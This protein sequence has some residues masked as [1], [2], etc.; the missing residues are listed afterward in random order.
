MSRRLSLAMP[1]LILALSIG[2]AAKA[3]PLSAMLALATL[4]LV[5]LGPRLELDKGRQ[6]LTSAIGGATGY[7]SATLLHEHVR[8]ALSEGWTRFASA[9]LLAAAVRFLIIAVRGGELPELALV[10]VGLLATGKTRDPAYIG[11]V[12][13]F[14]LSTLYNVSSRSQQPPARKR[15]LLG[16]ALLLI[17]AGLGTGTTLGVR[18]LHALASGRARYT[19][20]TW[21]PQIGFSDNMDLGALQGLLDSDE[22]V[23]RVRGARVDYLRGVSLD[24]YEAG[25]WRKSEAAEQSEDAQYLGYPEAPGRVTIT[26]LAEG[27]RFFLPLERRALTTSPAN[28]RVDGMTA[29]E[30]LSKKSLLTASFLPVAASD[31]LA[32][33]RKF[34]RMVPRRMRAKLEALAKEWT[35]GSLTASEELDALERHLRTEFVYS[36]KFERHKRRDPLVDFLFHRRKGHCEY[37]ASALALLARV[38]GIPTRV[39]MG[40]RVAERSPF[41]YYMVRQRNAHAWVEAWLPEQG[42]LTRD[43]T[44]GEHLPQN[45]DHQAGLLES[46]VDA[47]GVAYDDVTAWLGRLT[48]LQTSVA[49]LSGSLVLAWIVARGRRRRTRGADPS[50]EPLAFFAHFLDELARAG[51]AR[52]SDE[53]IERLRARV[54]DEAAAELLDRYVALRYGDMG[55]GEELARDIG[56]HS[57]ARRASLRSEGH[58]KTP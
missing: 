34:D 2:S 30:S 41:G 38:R 51:H 10:F 26:H 16:A 49:W 8:G 9:T 35:A 19:A 54:P 15:L 45:R 4:V 40:Y 29:I 32:P 27:S 11:F 3:W 24:L 22:R 18:H 1:M 36:Q 56:A 58:G 13:C 44:P 52:S 12:F 46:S 53:T 5:W 17:A 43:A 14:L 25:H 42:W 48:L 57:K 47:V 23:L 55:S 37:F 50:T 20:Y 39:V 33:P 28:V 7:L 31:T 6:L 21:R